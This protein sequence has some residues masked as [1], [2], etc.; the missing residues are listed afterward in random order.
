MREA[1]VSIVDFINLVN[2]RYCESPLL[3]DNEW[4]G[5]DVQDLLHV[6]ND[7]LQLE[8]LRLLYVRDGKIVPEYLRSRPL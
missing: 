7:G 8:D 4:G 3:L 1:L 5:E 2:V 6:L